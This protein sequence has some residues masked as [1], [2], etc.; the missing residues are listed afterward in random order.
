[1]NERYFDLAGRAIRYPL[2]EAL[3]DVRYDE[4]S[5]IVML[6]APGRGRLGAAGAGPYASGQVILI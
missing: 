2:G 3:R 1:V 6:H 5:R 4:A